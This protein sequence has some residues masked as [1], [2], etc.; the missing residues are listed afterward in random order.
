VRRLTQTFRKLRGRSLTELRVRG[1]QAL[2]AYLERVGVLDPEESFAEAVGSSLDAESLLARFKSESR[3]RPFAGLANREATLVALR[4]H[5]PADEPVLIERADRA[6]S[7]QFDLLGYRNLSF[8]NPIDW[9]LDPVSGRTAP[10]LHW[11]RIRFLD[12]EAVGDHKVVWELNRHQ[13]FVTL[14]QAY[15]YTGDERYARAFAADVR[16]W[17][18]QCPP[19]VGMNWASSLEVAFR[20]ISWVWALHL[21]RDS[22]SLSPDLFAA[23]LA[24]LSVHARH[25][26][27]NLSTYFSPN[28]HLT[29]E[30]L[31]LYYIAW[32]FPE[33]S[34]ADRWLALGEEILLQQIP[35]HVRSDGVYFEQSSYYHRYTVDFYLHYWLAAN[36]L[37]EAWPGRSVVEEPL[38]GLLRHML[39]ITRPDGTS[40]LYGDDDGGRLLF[41]D[42]RR[43]DDFRPSLSTGAA[44]FA[45]PELAFVAARLSGETVWL[46]GPAGAATW[47]SLAPRAP[48]RTSTGFQTSGFYVMR[49]GWGANANMLL[50]D[51]GPHGILNCGHAHADALA[52]DVCAHGH[53]MLADP[54][55]FTYTTSTEERNA[56][57]SSL[58]HTALSVDDQ[59]S[60]APSTPFAWESKAIAVARRWYVDARF[61]FFE[62]SH[63]GYERLPDPVGYDRVIFFV[64]GDYWIIRDRLSAREAHT[65]RLS[66]Q[67]APDVKVATLGPS[68]F[69]LCAEGAALDV[70]CLPSAGTLTVDDGWTSNAY[71][72]RSA[73]PRCNYSMF[74][75]TAGEITTV[76]LP[77]AASGD[78]WTVSGNEEPART[79][80][81]LRR[82]DNHDTFVVD[83]RGAVANMGVV[84][85][86][87]Y[88]W[89]RSS[90]GVGVTECVAIGVRELRVDDRS[91]VSSDAPVAWALVERRGRSW[92]E[93]RAD[94]NLQSG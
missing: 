72:V 22:A 57:R 89:I 65:F 91:V 60:S 32:S 42:P 87:D 53:T 75:S 44:V 48:E 47:T 40:P 62:G 50:V 69:A 24:S 33:L 76:M 15:W 14:G 54:G 11:S 84:A 46:T 63:D 25:L 49:D 77:R 3:R 9:S 23:T 61:D 94:S 70:M 34:G 37:A 92:T 88:C 79:D 90:E 13:Y 93:R 7:G 81:S 43:S 28:T 26:E 5:C 18:E 30:A 58:A 12:Y 35:R 71:G 16:H 67:V 36:R 1:R 66:F 31:G 19:K 45:S 27:A 10:K 78:R 20:A 64:K 73:A 59:S 38:R 29:G 83:A 8:G 4:R 68:T 82:G 80:L 85:H 52:L 2:T 56:F 55:T 17:L 21:F 74:A 6:C 39:A 41:L 51:C 86:A